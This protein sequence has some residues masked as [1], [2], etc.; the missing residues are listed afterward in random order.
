MRLRHGLDRVVGEAVAVGLRRDERVVGRAG[1]RWGV[2]DITTGLIV[3]SIGGRV[4]HR[5][6]ERLCERVDVGVAGLAERISPVR[7]PCAIQEGRA[8]SAAS[9]MSP[10]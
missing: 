8:E 6:A 10:C 5:C 1:G 7:H 4:E 9:V 2:L 3:W